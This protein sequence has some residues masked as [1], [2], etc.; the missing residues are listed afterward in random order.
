[1]RQPAAYRVLGT[2]L[3]IRLAQPLPPHDSIALDFEW[4][5]RIPQGGVGERMG[6]NADN[7]FFLAYWYPQMAV[8]DDVVGWQ[9]DA[10]LGN[11]EFYAGF[12][13]YDVTVDVPEG[14]LV[15]GTGQLVN[16]AEVLPENIVQRLRVAEASDTVVHVLTAADFGLER[17][18]LLWASPSCVHHSR[19]RGGLPKSDQ[20][21]SHAGEVLDRWIKVA[22]VDAKSAK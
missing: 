10:F 18:S 14:W 7:F 2:N 20:Q 1:M 13:D 4:S 12:A 8:Y 5:F 11:S 17:I 19:A 21:R 15:S 3:T 6:W 16:A 9:N 22:K